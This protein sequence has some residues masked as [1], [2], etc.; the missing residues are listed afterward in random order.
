M[1]KAHAGSSVA[2]VDTVVSPRLPLAAGLA[3]AL[4]GLPD[5]VVVVDDAGRIVMANERVTA[6]L[7]YTPAD[8]ARRPLETVLPR[9]AG[10]LPRPA[11]GRELL[12]RRSDGTEVWVEITAS[13]LEELTLIDL[14]DAGPRRTVRE[15][16]RRSEGSLRAVLAGL[17]DAT[18]ASSRDGRIVFVNELAEELFGYRSEQLVGRPVQTIW[19]ERM[20]DR[21]RRNMQ[22]Y[23]ATEHPLRF[24]ERAYGLRADGSEFV[25]EMSWGIV[26]TDEG[27]LLLAVGRDI[28]ERLAVERQLRRQ[29]AQQIAVATLGELAL[30][31]ADAC[32]L[33][34]ATPPTVGQA[35]SADRVEI[36]RGGETVATWGVAVSGTTPIVL[37]IRRE[38]LFGTLTTWPSP[39]EGSL[40]QDTTF[41]RSVVNVLATALDRLRRDERTRHQALHD[42]LTGLANRVLCHDRLAQALAR[43]RRGSEAAG[44]LFLDL[45]DFKAVN[46]QHGHA[47]GD[48]VLVAL[49]ERLRVAVRPSDTVARLGGDEFVVVC[50]DI[51]ERSARGLAERLSAAVRAH[52]LTVSIGIA[53]G[54]GD[55]EPATLLEAADA[56]AY[57][58]KGAGGDRIELAA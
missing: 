36:E 19:P 48:E 21:Y 20:R 58:A 34:R 31:G 44:V 6:L 17:P 26:R 29:S 2:D 50:E 41:L 45:D 15:R 35:M 22:L 12:A 9:G 1:D 30:S 33:L 38:E 49:A 37:D 13:R 10:S 52:D 40:E 55:T 11:E 46:D 7:G 57:R 5:A 16:L 18:V 54:D 25:G 23:F 42:P 27:P 4:I 32:E 39:S 28:T 8:L 14:R 56:A 3:A 51:D 53:L 43:A 47:R 24:T